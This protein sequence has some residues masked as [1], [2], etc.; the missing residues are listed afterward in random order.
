M[1]RAITQSAI[2][3]MGSRNLCSNV[4]PSRLQG[5]VAVV[6]A[7]TDGIGF[8]IAERLGREGAKVVV[9]SRKEQ[10]VK[11]AVDQL[12]SAGLDVTGVKCHVANA[13]DRKALFETAMKQYGGIDILVSN[14]AVNPEVGAVLDA[15]EEAWDKI[16]DVNVK[17]SFLLAKEAL[18]LIRQRKSG[19]SIVFV[20]SIAGFQPFSLLGAYSVSKT[21]LFGLTKAAS[22]DLAPE[23]I[24]V[25]CIAPGI[26]R[27]KF[28]AA[29]QDSETARATALEKIPMNRFAEPKEI[30]GVCAFLVS[31]DA[32]YITGET[33]VASGGMS[34][35]L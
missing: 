28:A 30:A 23:N 22:Q 13:A 33:I 8:A 12:K 4:N 10:N 5:K 26:V 25:N 16:F 9:S 29:L 3:T 20:S 15:S 17:C 7:S 27:T 14:A 32:S 1:L 19:G 24:R 31:E 35:R 18:P 2:V 6:T 21:A 34:S 11:K